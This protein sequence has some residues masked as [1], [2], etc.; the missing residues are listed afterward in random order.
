MLKCVIKFAYLK[1]TNTK[2]CLVIVIKHSG[3]DAYNYVVIRLFHYLYLIYAGRRKFFFILIVFF[4]S[5]FIQLWI[6]KNDENGQKYY[7]TLFVSQKDPYKSFIDLLRRLPK[8]PAK[9]DYLADR[10]RRCASRLC[11]AAI[12]WPSYR[13]EAMKV[14]AASPMVQRQSTWLVLHLCYGI[15]FCI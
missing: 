11:D 8:I 15:E 5:Q 1:A 9:T 4:Q 10:K 7:F 14:Q 6:M 13:I 3:R 2:F 12:S